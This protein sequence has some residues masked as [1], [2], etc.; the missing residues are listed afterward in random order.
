MFLF[1][2]IPLGGSGD[3]KG[4]RDWAQVNCLQD[5]CLTH[6]TIFPSCTQ[7]L[8]TFKVPQGWTCIEMHHL[9]ASVLHPGDTPL[10]TS[11]FIYS[12]MCHPTTT[13]KHLPHC[14]HGG[15]RESHTQMSRCSSIKKMFVWGSNLE[16]PMT[17]DCLCAQKLFLD[18]DGWTIYAAG[19]RIGSVI[20]KLLYIFC[21]CT[22]SLVRKCLSL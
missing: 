6:S 11:F 8:K 15:L 16:A 12:L 13:K 7:V 1:S 5:K 19:D 10:I 14:W 20:F 21:C 2:G 18:T 17:C 3:H 22:L 9:D 4:A